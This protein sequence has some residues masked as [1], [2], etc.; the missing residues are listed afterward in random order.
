MWQLRSRFELG[1]QD[2]DF[3]LATIGQETNKGRPVSLAPELELILASRQHPRAVKVKVKNL[4][5]KLI[6]CFP[7]TIEP[8]NQ[9]Q[10]EKPE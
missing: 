8:G 9:S 1:N 2:Q 6:E 5:D 4:R 3:N 10:G 7:L